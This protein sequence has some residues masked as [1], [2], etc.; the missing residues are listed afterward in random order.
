MEP[1]IYTYKITFPNQGWWYWGVHKERKYG[2]DYWGSPSSHKDKWDWFEFE[3]QIL[4]F[5]DDYREANTVEQRLI[6]PDLNNPM[7]LNMSCGGSL[8]DLM[9]H[10]DFLSEWHK[11]Q[12]EEWKEGMRERGRIM[13]QKYGS[14][15]VKKMNSKLT[16][17]KRREASYKR[18]DLQESGSGLGRS[19]LGKKYCTDG[20]SNR[21]A[22][23]G[24]TLPDGWVWG[25]AA[26]HRKRTQ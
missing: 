7:C 10:S 26:I 3:K 17:E 5:F 9:A 25:T 6:K 4:E 15:N 16:T 2:E 18:T 14:E 12:G 23:P 1:R 13:N 20:V 21:K 19:N 8:S 24:D 11:S 22:Y